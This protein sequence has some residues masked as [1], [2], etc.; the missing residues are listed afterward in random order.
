ML[1]PEAY[2]K[3]VVKLQH[4]NLTSLLITNYCRELKFYVLIS[5]KDANLE[6]STH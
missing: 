4:S 3:L 1:R 2:L 5:E 6:K